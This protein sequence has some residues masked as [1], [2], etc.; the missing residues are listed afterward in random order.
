MQ[1]L[2]AAHKM[3]SFMPMIMRRIRV[4]DTKAQRASW[5]QIRFVP[6]GDGCSDVNYNDDLGAISHSLLVHG[7]EAEG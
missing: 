4:R 5:I 7:A 6:C 1:K 3:S 2:L